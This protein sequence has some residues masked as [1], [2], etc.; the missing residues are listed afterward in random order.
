[1]TLT[2]PH[3]NR[4]IKVAR[5]LIG[6]YITY[7]V[8]LIPIGFFIPRLS[9]LTLFMA[10]MLTI[11]ANRFHLSS[12]YKALLLFILTSFLTGV[13]L[14]PDTNMV[15]NKSLFLLESFLAGVIVFNV[16]DSEDD[17]SL[18]IGIYALGALIMSLFIALNPS[19]MFES[20]DRISV[21]ENFNPN[22]MGIILMYGIWS[23]IFYMNRKGINALGVVV[24]IALSFFIF[25]VI[26]Q[27]GSRKAAISSLFIFIGYALYFFIAKGGTSRRFSYALSVPVFIAVIV[28]V[29]FNYIDAFLESSENLMERMDKLDVDGEDRWS[30]ILDSFRVWE[31][32]PIFGV[33]LDNNRYFTHTKLYAHNTYAEL[34]ACTGLV[35]ASLFLF[36]FWRMISFLVKRIRRIKNLFHTPSCY[37]F[38]IIILVYLFIC[39]VQ[40]S[41]YNRTHMFFLYFIITYISLNAP[42]YEEKGRLSI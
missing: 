12:S 38:V 35:G 18:I 13:L 11:F 34:F 26:I 39:F 10:G 15:I 22:T 40:I 2:R 3:N 25:Y 37:Y 1:M 41:F 28:F 21:D 30:I 31:E 4:A 8:F 42:K 5:F 23:V 6:F 27:T 29:Y 16:T 36:L 19:L 7:N 14:A 17:I 20:G 9:I 32:H 24:S 33:G